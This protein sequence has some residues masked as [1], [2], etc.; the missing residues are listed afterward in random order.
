VKAG[1]QGE[2][3][4]QNAFKFCSDFVPLA[5]IGELELESSD[6]YAYNI[7][8]A[9]RLGEC[10]VARDAHVFVFWNMT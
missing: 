5:G 4:A 2:D 1:A 3:N 9:G 8:P 6:C 7:F 10:S